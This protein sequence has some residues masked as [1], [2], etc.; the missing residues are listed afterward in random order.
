M[1][2]CKSVLYKE[3]EFQD[4]R[5]LL[6][7][8]LVMFVVSAVFRDLLSFVRIWNSGRS[9]GSTPGLFLFLGVET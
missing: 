5:L 8:S 9:F 4:K 2:S 6:E 7:F 1:L 3:T